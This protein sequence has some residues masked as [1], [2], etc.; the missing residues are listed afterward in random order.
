MSVRAKF[1]CSS[2]TLYPNTATAELNAIY[3]TTGENADFATATPSGKL[4]VT[5]S[6]G[7]PAA[8]FFAPGKS[9]YLDFSEAPQ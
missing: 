7:V 6:A 8:N 1:Q 3:S 4:V 9:Y 5:I 2:I